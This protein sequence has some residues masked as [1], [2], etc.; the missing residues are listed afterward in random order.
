MSAHG[1]RYRTAREAI[2][3]EQA[4]TPLAAVRLL[5]EL[6]GA[7]SSTRPSRCTSGSA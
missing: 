4:Y 2:D 1:K 7:R 6:A 3:R 5:K